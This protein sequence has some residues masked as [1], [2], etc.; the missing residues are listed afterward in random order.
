MTI[1]H[2]FLLCETGALRTRRSSLADHLN[3]WK[4]PKIRASF[5]M[6]GEALET[7]HLEIRLPPRFFSLFI[8]IF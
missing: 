7:W 1:L 5:V 4:H 3:V 6:C 8:F 2:N